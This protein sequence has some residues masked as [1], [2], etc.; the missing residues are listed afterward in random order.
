MGVAAPD[1]TLLLGRE[2]VGKSA[3][4]RALTGQP[5]RNVHFRGTTVPCGE[6][7]TPG[8]VF[9][10][11][12]GLHR[13]S[14]ADTVRLT[15]EALQEA[16]EV[17]LVASAT[18][19]DEDLDLLLPLVQ[20]RRASVAVTRWD[21]VADHAAAREAIARMALETGLPFVVLDARHPDPAALEELQAAVAAPGAVRHERTPVRAGLRIEPR[22][23]LLDHAVAGP[24]AG[25]ALLVLPA[26]LAVLAANQAAAWLEPLVDSVTIP[27]AERIVGWP[28]PLGAMLA[29][30]YGLLTMGPLLFVW[31]MPTVLVYAVLLGVYK[32]SGLADRIGTAI[33]PLLR[34]I[35]L[36]GR[37]VTRVLMGFG[38]NVPAIV[39]TR[40]CSACTRP[41][42]V[43]AIAFGSACS[44]QL[45]AT[46][47]VFAAAGRSSLVGPYLA[48]LVAA[49]L[50]YARLTSDPVARSPLNT[51]LIEPRTFLTRPSLAAVGEE[52]RGMVSA[53]L[54]TAVPTF[55]AIAMVASLLD[56]SGVLDA[57]GRVL[58]PAMAV[59]ALPVE[60]ALPTVLAAIRKDGILLLAEEGTV[61]SLS[62]SQLL[63]ATFLAGTVLP[64]LVTAI[65][66]GRELGLR[67]TGRLVVQQA[68][69]AVAVSA[70]VGWASAFAGW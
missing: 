38:C 50:V 24:A 64:C 9:V 23:G 46:L 39:S 55:F 14:D 40:S 26:L 16:D 31:A 65:T 7:T 22:R 29:G 12:P 18:Q 8:R 4:A 51:L 41:T 60:A 10:D 52:T 11:T 25:V 2:S 59:F 20:G 43:G 54:R 68:A 15:L 42:T 27:L 37:D 30:D 44:Y 19:L 5:A 34:P 62:A 36:H 58:G 32:A 61:A 69:F 57:A 63:V 53:F 48:L 17:L 67:F 1:T 33:H 28:G 6:Y 13:A 21:L 47:A 66:I 3:L 56:W 35:G 70:A 45:G 49:T